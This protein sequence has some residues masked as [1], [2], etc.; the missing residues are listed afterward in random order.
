MAL[1]RWGRSDMDALVSE[2][3]AWS[4]GTR[5]EQRAAAAALCE[6][7]LLRD[8]DQCGAVLEILDHITRSI[9]GA[10]DRRTEEF[11][12]LRQALGYC[13]SVAASAA[14]GLGVPMLGEWMGTT[15]TDV[16]WVMRQN[17]KKER[18]LRLEGVPIDEWLAL[19]R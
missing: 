13:W 3:R 4:E 10:T 2:M 11:R 18:L 7:A 9:E 17:L 1:Q 6:P 12:V 19:T 16:R 5:L 15:D 14:P 8:Q